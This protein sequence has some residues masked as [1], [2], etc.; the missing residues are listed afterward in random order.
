MAPLVSVGTP[1]NSPTYFVAS[2]PDTFRPTPVAAGYWGDGV[3]SGPAVAG[4]AAWA[5]DDRFG[6]TDLLPSRFTIDLLRPATSAPTTVHTRVLRDG[7]RMRSSE[8]DVVQDGRL[9]AR[10]TMLQYLI[11]GA[12]GGLEWTT[13]SSFEPPRDASGDDVYVGSEEVGWSPMGVHHQ[14]VQR[15]RAYY[16]GCDVVAGRRT[17][18]FVRSVIVAEAATNLVTNLGTEGIGYIN[19]DLTVALSRL[20][21]SEHLGIQADSHW[22]AD[23]ISVG[24]ATLFDESGPFGTGLVTAI[25]NPAARI[26]FGGTAPVSAPGA[27]L[28]TKRSA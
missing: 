17:S 27:E 25:A 8:C 10:A 16:R 18:P 2:G 7:R 26:D 24:N 21:R 4:L 6:A 9:V 1:A 15:K 19:G 11:S 12:P 23:G 5:L 20:P 28:F 22:S 13:E 14:N 3:L